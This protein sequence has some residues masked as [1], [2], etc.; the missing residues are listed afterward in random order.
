MIY[1]WS[2]NGINIADATNSTLL[3]ANTGVAQQGTYRVLV[4]NALGT[5][6]SQPATAWH[7]HD[8]LD[9]VVRE[10]VEPIR[11]VIRNLAVRMPPGPFVRMQM[12]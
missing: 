9:A 5:A 6:L 11:R 2:F 4:T 1:Q 10:P 8:G 3:I 7:A 12:G